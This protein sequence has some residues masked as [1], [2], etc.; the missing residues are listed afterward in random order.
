MEDLT[1]SLSP[2]SSR[3]VSFRYDTTSC[4]TPTI[5]ATI[6]T[7]SGMERSFVMMAFRNAGRNATQSQVFTS[8]KRFT[9]NSVIEN[10]SRL[11]N[12]D[13]ALRWRQRFIS[14]RSKTGYST[15]LARYPLPKYNA[16]ASNRT[17]GP[18]CRDP[19][20]VIGPAASSIFPR[21]LASR[22]V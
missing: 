15:S 1:K 9:T 13:S 12:T 8:F 2:S 21:I 6:S 3:P 7:R 10:G 19:L 14:W 5:F 20:D 4:H 18:P 11:P 22:V 17:C 16:K